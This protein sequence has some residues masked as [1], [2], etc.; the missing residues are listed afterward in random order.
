MALVASIDSLSFLDDLI[1]YA[2]NS[3]VPT[4]GETTLI[5]HTVT[6]NGIRLRSIVVG[7]N[8]K[9]RFFLKKNSVEILSVRNSWTGRTKEISTGDE[10]F[11]AG[12]V[13]LIS[14][15]NDSNGINE[16]EAR[17]NAKKL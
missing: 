15:E 6:D 16:Y 8:D 11:V 4:T 5:S 9:G 3:S 10:E 2:K 14:V 13:L 1:L 7:G 12:D 17:I